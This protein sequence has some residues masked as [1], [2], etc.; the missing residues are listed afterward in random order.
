M[1]QILALL[2]SML[3]LSMPMALAQEEELDGGVAPDS[4][5]YGVDKALDRISLALSRGK[6]AKTEKGLKIAQ[7]RLAEAQAMADQGKLEEAEEAQLEHEEV[8]TEASTTLEEL[9]TNGSVEK[10]K[11]A[12]EEVSDLQNK[13]ES[14]YDKV[15][16][17]KEGILERQREKMSPEQLAKLEQ[18]FNKIQEKAKQVDLKTEE[19]KDKVKLRYKTLSEKTDSE[20]ETELEEIEERV[21]LKQDREA[22]HDKAVTRAEK[23]IKEAKEKLADLKAEGKDVSSLE[24]QILKQEALLK[25]LKANQNKKVTTDVDELGNE[26]SAVARR[27]GEA[28]KE[29]NFDEVKAELK[30]TI[31]TRHEAVKTRVEKKKATKESSEAREE[32][33]EEVKEE[34]PEVRKAKEKSNGKSMKDN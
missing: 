2:I 26:V 21:S 27:L 11:E 25:E 33:T 20:V 3:V 19:K 1:K 34:K 7:E 16:E 14:H 9:E 30:K 4:V 28:K 13:V 32:K 12:L 10:S 15:R 8:L 29:G 24:D 6:A 18:V 5:F 22:R 17:V 31:E 23:A